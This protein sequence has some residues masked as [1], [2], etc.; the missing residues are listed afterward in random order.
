MTDFARAAKAAGEASVAHREQV[1]GR[2]GAEILRRADA[3]ALADAVTD[4][5]RPISSSP[6]S[7]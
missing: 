7:S 1:E 4:A 2:A 3:I 5:A 6:I